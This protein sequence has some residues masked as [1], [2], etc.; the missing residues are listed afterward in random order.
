MT[1]ADNEPTDQTLVSELPS[2]IRETRAA[3]ND[4]EGFESTVG[5]TEINVPLG[6]TSLVVGDELGDY[7]Y[8]S[9]R[10]TAVGPAVLETITNGTDGQ[11]KVIVFQDTDIDLLD[12]DAQSGGT[13]Y[14]EQLP[15]GQELNPQIGDVI[16]L[17]NIGGSPGIDDGYWKEL[18]RTISVK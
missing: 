5:F 12:S 18:Y 16:A 15:S 8:E 1:L 9:I 4:I 3:V 14:L 2:Y 11:V 6:E 7:G 17:M 13:F 10:M